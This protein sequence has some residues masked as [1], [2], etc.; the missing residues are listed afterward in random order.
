MAHRHLAH[1][2]LV[3]VSH[4]ASPDLKGGEINFSYQQEE[5]QIHV[6]KVWPQGEGKD[7]GHFCNPSA[8]L[9]MPTE[10]VTAHDS[11]PLSRGEHKEPV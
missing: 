5:M 9:R 2:L 11:T 7:W 4:R 10:V 8:A 1:I 6:A 3:K